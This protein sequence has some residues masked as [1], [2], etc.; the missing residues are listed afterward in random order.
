LVTFARDLAPA[1]LAATIDD[2]RYL[3]LSIVADISSYIGLKAD[4]YLVIDCS[5]STSGPPMA[6]AMSTHDTVITMQFDLGEFSRRCF[7]DPLNTARKH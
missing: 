1:A 6:T 5:R 7:P 2:E 4:M 3:G